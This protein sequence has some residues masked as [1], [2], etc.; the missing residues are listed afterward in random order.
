MLFLEKCSFS[1]CVHFSIGLFTFGDLS[2]RNSR[3]ILYIHLLSYMLL[4]NIYFTFIG[5]IWLFSLM[6][7]NFL[8]HLCFCCLCFSAILKKN[9]QDKCQGTIFLGF[10]KT[11]WGHV[12]CLK[13]QGLRLWGFC[14]H[15]VSF[16]SDS[17]HLCLDAVS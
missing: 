9:C 3:C 13:L 10:R 1:L 11:L 7:R 6:C 17:S 14:V 16:V 5:S 4:V 8:V 15:G 12:L 2:W